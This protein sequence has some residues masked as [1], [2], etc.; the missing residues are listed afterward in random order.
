M[1]SSFGASLLSILIAT[2]SLPSSPG[3]RSTEA[4]V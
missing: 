3:M 2:V 1:P 4:T